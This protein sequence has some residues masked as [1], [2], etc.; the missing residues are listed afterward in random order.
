MKNKKEPP[1]RRKPNVL[2]YAYTKQTI[3]RNCDRSFYPC[4]TDSK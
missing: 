1:E 4:K 3:L 2:S